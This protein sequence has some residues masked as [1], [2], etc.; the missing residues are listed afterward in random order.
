MDE[1]PQNFPKNSEIHSYDIST[2]FIETRGWVCKLISDMSQQNTNI[3]ST[4]NTSVYYFIQL[5]ESS[6]H[7]IR[8]SGKVQDWYDK[9]KIYFN[10]LD[11]INERQ[12][13]PELLIR[14]WRCL[15]EDIVSGGIYDD[16]EIS[17]IKT[18]VS[19]MGRGDR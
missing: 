13:L 16:G 2:L 11:R 7:M 1:K 9:E 3:V 5:F 14:M 10:F 18:I 12:F 19:L 15:C 6:R 8:A 17:E 4:Y